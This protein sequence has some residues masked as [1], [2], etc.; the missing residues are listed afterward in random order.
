MKTTK[1]TTLFYLTVTTLSLLPTAAQS[2]SGSVSVDWS[3]LQLNVIDTNLSDGITPQI[4]WLDQTTQIGRYITGL[5]GTGSAYA[6]DWTSYGN[7]S[8][9]IPN[10]D[11]NAAF[12]ASNL[13]AVGVISG[14]PKAG[15]I[16]LERWGYFTVSGDARIEA[17]VNASVSVSLSPSEAGSVD[18]VFADANLFFGEG[19]FNSGA[20]S[21]IAYIKADT[22]SLIYSDS[23]VLSTSIELQKNAQ[24][25]LA[26]QP[27]VAVFPVAVP[28]PGA[29]WLMSSSMIVFGFVGKARSAKA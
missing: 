18:R 1:L 8:Y 20:T 2:A 25:Y 7:D 12:S 15:V 13:S 5:G 16:R 10:I 4:E 26:T 6:L 28:L 29:F 21:Y 23:G 17:S 14:P 3:T 11:F 22:A 24:V 19:T 27:G 9:S